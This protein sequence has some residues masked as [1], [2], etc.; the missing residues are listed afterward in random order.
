MHKYTNILHLQRICTQNM[1]CIWT[2]YVSTFP[3]KNWCKAADTLLPSIIINK[4]NNINEY[5]PKNI[6]AAALS[7]PKINNWRSS[8]ST[9]STEGSPVAV[10]LVLPGCVEPAASVRMLV[11]ELRRWKDWW[12]EVSPSVPSSSRA[13]P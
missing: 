1:T 12:P 8:C 2:E 13:S 5:M 4:S 11:R 6:P 7:C 10:V 3:R 9:S